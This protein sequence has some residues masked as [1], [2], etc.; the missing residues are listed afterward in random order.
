MQAYLSAPFHLPS[1]ATSRAEFKSIFYDSGQLVNQEWQNI[2]ESRDHMFQTSEKI[3]WR[4]CCQQDTPRSKGRIRAAGNA[5]MAPRASSWWC[6]F[7]RGEWTC[8]HTCSPP[9]IL[10]PTCRILSR[11]RGM[12]PL[13]QR[14]PVRG[15]S[16]P[17]GFV[18]CI[19]DPTIMTLAQTSRASGASP[20]FSSCPRQTA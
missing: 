11:R 9:K 7:G 19:V 16:F 17:L 6:G 15:P 5:L 2:I 18:M 3:V 13:A 12:A 8:R 1:P 14:F 20:Q 10:P 4:G